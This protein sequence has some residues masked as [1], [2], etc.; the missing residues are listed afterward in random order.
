MLHPAPTKYNINKVYI[1]LLLSSRRRSVLRV[2]NTSSSDEA[3]P[4]APIFQL[5]SEYQG[6]GGGGESKLF[7]VMTTR[8]HSM[9][10]VSVSR[11]AHGDDNGGVTGYRLNGIYDG[12]VPTATPL[13]GHV[14]ANRCPL[15]YILK[16]IFYF[17]F[18]LSHTLL[19]LGIGTVKSL[20]WRGQSPVN[21]ASREAQDLPP[22]EIGPPEAKCLRH[23]AS[24]LS[25]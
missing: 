19:G 13:T 6:R 22:A 20:K 1:L 12:T 14:L 15:F 10:R 11:G 9:A 23:L 5:S 16:H 4:L 24:Y 7:C 2:A 25:P 8:L 18:F 17:L 21:G 3:T